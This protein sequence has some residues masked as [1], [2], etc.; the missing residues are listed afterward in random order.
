MTKVQCAVVTCV[1]NDFDA[2][3]DVGV[4]VLEKL[5]IGANGECKNKEILAAEKN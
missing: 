3:A 2:H 5:S 4:C 1:H